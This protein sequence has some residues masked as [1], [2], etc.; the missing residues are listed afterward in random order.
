[1]LGEVARTRTPCVST[2]ADTGRWD[3]SALT[4]GRIGSFMHAPIE[5]GPRLFGVISVAHEES[6]RFG[7]AELE[8]LVKLARSSAAAIANAIDFERE[9]R[10]ARALTLGFVPTP[11]PETPGYEVGLLY[12]PA[13]NEPAGGDVYGAW[14]LPGGGMAVLIGD[15]A[16]KGVETAALSAMVRFFIEARSW[17][18]IRPS[19]VLA[20]ANAV[21]S[22]RL[23]GDTFVTAFFGILSR[24]RI[25]WC[26]AGHHPPLLLRAAAGPRPLRGGGLPLGIDEAPAYGEGDLELRSGDVLFA[27]T[28]GMIEARREGETFGV[29]R[30]S[31]FVACHRELGPERLVGAAHDEV[32]S[33]ADGL[34]DDAVALALRRRPG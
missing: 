11:L 28:D 30:L 27:Y 16:G 10:I 7:E 3:P 9:R 5:L 15:V 8:L 32:A 20:Q 25:R 29:G 34:S 23:S 4:A 26:N 31:R 13:S 12:A 17:D 22:S 2:A 6:G 19:T 24:V 1:M 14:P 21:L 33:W 18:S